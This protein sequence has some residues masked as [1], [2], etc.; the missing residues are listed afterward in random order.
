MKKEQ[1]ADQYSLTPMQEGMLFHSLS[2]RRPGVDVE[3]IFCAWHEDVNVAAFAAPVANPNFF[4]LLPSSS[5]G[6][7]S[8]VSSR[9]I[10]CRGSVRCSCV[11][12]PA[13]SGL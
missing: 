1:I 8:F 10:G 2:V 13:R 3:Q 12:K 4:M 11:V 5:F 9:G 6:A 7:S